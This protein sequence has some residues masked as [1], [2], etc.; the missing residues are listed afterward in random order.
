MLFALS[1]GALILFVLPPGKTDI[2]RALKISSKLKLIV[3]SVYRANAINVPVRQ[4]RLVWSS[5]THAR[6]RVG[7]L[8]DRPV[9]P[10]WLVAVFEFLLHCPNVEIVGV[11]FSYSEN[12]KTLSS[13][14]LLYRWYRR[15]DS[16]RGYTRT[17]LSSVTN[18][19]PET[20]QLTVVPRTAH[21]LERGDYD[22]V[23]RL[24]VDVFL[25]CGWGSLSQTIVRAAR[26][27]VWSFCYG[28]NRSTAAAVTGFWEV[29]NHSHTSMAGLLATAP[30]G[31]E[32][33]LGISEIRTHPTS[34]HINGIRLQRSSIAL[35]EYQIGRLKNN[36]QTNVENF[37]AN[38]R[39]AALPR[40]VV[41]THSPSNLEMLE[42]ISSNA[43]A[44]IRGR[45][46]GRYRL[47][48]WTIGF[49]DEQV[50]FDGG[51]TFRNVQWL[52][53]QGDRFF[54]DPFLVKDNDRR[55]LFVEEYPYSARQGHISVAEVSASGSLSEFTPVLER[56]FHLSFP[57]VFVHDGRHY[58][59]PE[60]ATTNSIVLYEAIR[61]PNKWQEKKVIVDNFPGVDNTLIYHN[62]R[63][64]LFSTFGKYNN[65]D[66][67]L[68]LFS[69]NDLFGEFK[70]H[71]Q[72]PVKLDIRSSRM[73]G[74]IIVRDGKLI[75]PAQ[76]CAIRYGGS[77]ILNEILELN[78][79][80]YAERPIAEIIPNRQS[81]FRAGL[82][83]VNVLD[84]TTVVTGL[85]YISDPRGAIAKAQY[86]LWGEITSVHFS[87]LGR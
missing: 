20:P 53:T 56:P 16:R 28:G 63:W 83:T 60:Q 12:P 46:E 26:Y 82:H 43:F 59:L 51:G 5:M 72:N 85:R 17:G 27:G 30:D 47:D 67:N 18:I 15:F 57:F 34:P 48:Q 9:V 44:I 21:E 14:S 2:L 42:F 52:P 35:L 25:D 6:V 1:L 32:Y 64:W 68:H 73:A 54:A 81:Q 78:E 11:L 50:P 4:A 79:A 87:S 3:R 13:P 8:L 29:F 23:A 76:N 75:R 37:F 80:R 58:M 10:R 84:H 22:R 62:D 39:D 7:I 71:P 65:Q 69:A 38:Y 40:P 86:D 70:P 36:D 41:P 45:I 31:T 77:I 61:F 74:S 19:L 49:T 24:N 55:F 33:S 66:N